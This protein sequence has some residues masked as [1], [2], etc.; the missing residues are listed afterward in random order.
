[1]E[2]LRRVKDPGELDR[3]AEAARIAD[4]ALAA[5][6]PRLADGPTEADFGRALD[7][8]M[9]ALGATAPSFE[10]IVASGPNAAMPHHRPGSR[11]IGR[12]EPVVI[13]FGALFDG[14]CSDMTRTVWVDGVGDPDTA[15][16]GGAGIRVAG[17]RGGRGEAGSGLRRCRPGLP[18]G[19]RGCGLG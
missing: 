10:T 15:G 11:P 2:A 9:R 12:A 17:G 1:M 4:E 19:H 7:F 13:D 16:R 3:L 5:V 18:V 8:E 6:R 14:Y